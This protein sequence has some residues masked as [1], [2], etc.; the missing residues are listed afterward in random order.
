MI[1]KKTF[2][3]ACVLT[4]SVI[5]I[6]CKP[7]DVTQTIS[8]GR[9]LEKEID[10][11]G[12]ESDT[13]ALL[14]AIRKLSKNREINH[15]ANGYFALGRYYV[16]RKADSAFYYLN[17][18]RGNALKINSEKILAS[19]DFSLALLF[20]STDDF[21]EAEKYCLSSIKYS[22]SLDSSA[23][24]VRGKSL[25]G[26]IYV[27]IGEY[28]EAKTFFEE[29]F[30]EN[31]SSDPEM[32]LII[33]NNLG[34]MY[35]ENGD[36]DTAIKY[37]DS[38]LNRAIVADYPELYANL[39]DNLG[40][41]QFLKREI[42]KAAKNLNAAYSVRKKFGLAVD[43]VYSEQ[44]LADFYFANQNFS[45]GLFYSNRV[46]LQS[47]QKKWLSREY[48][49]LKILIK[50]NLP[51][52]NYYDDFISVEKRIK[53]RRIALNNKLSRIQFQTQELKE[54]NDYLIS[55][56]RAIV[57]FSGLI[58]AAL[59]VIVFYIRNARLGDQIKMAKLERDHSN[60]I[61]DL[62]AENQQVIE[63][64]RSEEKR[65]ISMELHDGVMNRLTSARLA[66]FASKMNLGPE[67]TLIIDELHLAEKEIRAVSHM[68]AGT[69]SDY[70]SKDLIPLL[71]KIVRVHE[72]IN[73]DFDLSDWD[74]LSNIKP[75]VRMS[76]YRLIQEAV[77]NI[78]K[79]SSEGIGK[80]TISEDD[81]NLIINAVN[82]TISP[83]TITKKGIG[84][85]NIKHRVN[86]LSGSFS[87]EVGEKFYLKIIL[88]KRNLYED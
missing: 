9:R 2:Q 82:S 53:R 23:L 37:Y 26:S 47:R 30:E 7:D 29:A 18:A 54:E 59:I 68:L 79:H 81:V 60:E 50:Y 12:I 22:R 63:N 61:Y 57:L 67:V 69:A 31:S 84:I 32:E 28:E 11:L 38:A 1:W 62:I 8:E 33:V 17:K 39:L 27:N 88:P 34:N 25:M 83:S 51:G 86:Q 58:V 36:L 71:K 6:G 75:S 72:S 20:F 13:I 85:D 78:I 41:T 4:V 52:L 48:E 14:S 70:S 64:T 46:L 15:R 10:Q 42:S 77:Q 73:L 3:L 74:V 24:R 21:V 87:I 65:R 45:K 80:I 16:Y 43:A 5:F 44:H 56:R 76:I 19:V 49:M 66:L 35:Q 40:Y 55:Q